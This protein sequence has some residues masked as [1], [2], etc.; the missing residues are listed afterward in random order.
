MAD[1]FTEITTQGW[2]SRVKNAF[3]GI[4]FGII[5]TVGSFPLLF[6]NEGRAVKRHQS[7]QEGAGLVQSVAADRIDPAHEGR[8]V[9]VTGTAEARKGEPLTD[10]DFGVVAPGGLKLRRKV[11]MYQ[12][13]EEQ[14]RETRNKTGGGTETVTTYN[15]AKRWSPELEKSANFH[16]PGGH[17]NPTSMPFPSDLRTAES[18]A[19]GAF[20]LPDFFVAQINDFQPLDGVKADTL[21]EALRGKV[22]PIENGFYVGADPAAPAVGDVRVSFSAVP[23]GLVS[24]VAQQ[25]GET[26]VK[27]RTAAGGE[28]EL[29]QMGTR[30]AAEMFAS[31]EQ[32]NKVLTW[33]LRL[34][35]FIAM[36]I[37]LSLV[38]QPLRVMADVLPLAGRVVGMG[39]GFFAFLVAGIGSTITIAVAWISYRPIIG[40]PVLVLTLGFFIWLVARLRK[41][42]PA[43][44]PSLDPASPAPP[45]LT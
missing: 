27:Y 22:K 11:E 2:G 28:I 33:A 36:A 20:T 7:L 6:L 31:A 4:I 10:P 13:T 8:L 1:E 40:I 16:H 41:A 12:W 24:V 43:A 45:P 19:L 34:A 32:A 3:G 44:A 35:G 9:H 5:L 23:A 37:G 30:S 14:R 29:L 39:I 38:A 25:S 15:Y 26:F 21:P 17:Q 18:I 42:R